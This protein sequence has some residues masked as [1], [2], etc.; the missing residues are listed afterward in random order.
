MKGQDRLPPSTVCQARE[1]AHKP[2][3][4]GLAYTEIPDHITCESQLIQ[5]IKS[6]QPMAC[7][8]TIYTNTTKEKM[9]KAKT[10]MTHS[11]WVYNKI[12]GWSKAIKRSNKMKKGYVERVD[13]S[14]S[15][16]QK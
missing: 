7:G 15:A 1:D 3:C 16:D 12:G 10:F 2:D 9:G 5:Y 4:V 13:T 14:H 8:G 11:F 6:R